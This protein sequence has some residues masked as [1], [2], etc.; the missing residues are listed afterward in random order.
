MIADNWVFI[1]AGFFDHGIFNIVYDGTT[2]Y[3]YEFGSDEGS[4]EWFCNENMEMLDFRSEGKSVRE[5]Y[6]DG[7]LYPGDVIFFQGH[8]QLTM[9]HLNAFDAGRM[10]TE[11]VSTGSKFK[12]WAGENQYPHLSVGFILRDKQAQPE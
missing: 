5:L 9:P 6:E 2:G 7:R 10:N 12:M 11:S 8:M 1:D 4:A 3:M